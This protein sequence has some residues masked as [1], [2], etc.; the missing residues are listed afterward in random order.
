[1]QMADTI[2]LD[3]YQHADGP[4]VRIIAHTLENILK[5]QDTIRMLMNREI[6][7]ISVREWGNVEF[8]GFYDL[9]LR[10]AKKDRRLL[11]TE[12]I[13]LRILRRVYD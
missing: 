1:M 3:Y 6:D 2:L 11:A 7:E 10:A 5:I 9:I 4:R 12:S 13:Y 8:T